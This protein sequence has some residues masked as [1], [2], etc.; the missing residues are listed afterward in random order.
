[1]R[2]ALRLPVIDV[3]LP[4]LGLFQPRFVQCRACLRDWS[5]YQNF[6]VPVWWVLLPA[7][8]P[9]N[10]VRGYRSEIMVVGYLAALCEGWDPVNCPAHDVPSWSVSRS[11]IRPAVTHTA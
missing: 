11:E 1:M 3:G 5:F 9:N 8:G 2:W 4:D 7:Q 10:L 6:S